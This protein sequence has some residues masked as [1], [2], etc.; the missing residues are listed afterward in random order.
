MLKRGIYQFFVGHCNISLLLFL[1]CLPVTIM[2]QTQDLYS[3]IE[4]SKGLKNKKKAI[5]IIDKS[6]RINGNLGV[7][8]N[9]SQGLNALLQ[10][11]RIRIEDNKTTYCITIWPDSQQGHDFI[12]SINKISLTI[13]DLVVGNIEPPPNIE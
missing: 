4:F 1:I 3:K 12:M 7:Y 6:L 10:Y 2:A 8:G 9:L 11:N 5:R 13:N